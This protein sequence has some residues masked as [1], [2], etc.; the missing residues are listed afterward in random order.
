VITSPPGPGQW[1]GTRVAFDRVG[2]YTDQL[3]Y[4]VALVGGLEVDP[5]P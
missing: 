2:L 5:H 3:H 1:R 4:I